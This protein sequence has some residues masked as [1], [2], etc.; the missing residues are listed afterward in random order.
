MKLLNQLEP[1]LARMHNRSSNLGKRMF[2]FV[3]SSQLIHQEEEIKEIWTNFL[4]KNQRNKFHNNVIY[5][6]VFLGHSPGSSKCNI[7][8]EDTFKK[9]L[10]TRYW[11]QLLIAWITI[12]I[13][14]FKLL[15][16]KP[17]GFM[18]CGPCG[19]KNLTYKCRQQ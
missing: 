6:P 10:R 19:F 13:C 4:M 15:K 12:V 7:D 16:M 5:R 17:P 2:R 14:K 3:H 9:N 8:F 1:S 18:E 11:M